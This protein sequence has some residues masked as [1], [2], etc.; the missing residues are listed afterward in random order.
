MT[1]AE[2]IADHLSSQGIRFIFG[3]PGSGFSLDLI[4]AASHRG[5]DFVATAHEGSAAMMAAVHGELT[6]IPGVCLSIRG[7]GAANLNSGI[8]YAWL[9]HSP[10]LAITETFSHKLSRP[11]ALQNLDHESVFS[12]TT[13]RREL[14]TPD[15]CLSTLWRTAVH[16]RPGPVHLDVPDGPADLEFRP[17]EVSLQE[18][19][20][21]DTP[22]ADV[23]VKRLRA[24]E[25]PVALVGAACARAGAGDALI[26][27]AEAWSIPVMTGVKARGLFPEDHP[28]FGGLFLAHGR[29]EEHITDQADLFL[30]IGWDRHEL[31]KE[32]AYEQRVLLLD[33]IDQGSDIPHAPEARVI[34]HLPDILDSLAV[35]GSEKWATEDVAAALQKLKERAEPKGP[36]FWPQ[37]VVEITRNL[38]PRDT[39]LVVETGIYQAVVEHVWISYAYGT[40]LGTLC[41]R[42]MGLALP[43]ALAAGLLRNDRRIVCMV[44]DGGLL[45][46]AGELELAGRMKVP[47]TLIVFNDRGLGTIRSRQATRGLERRGLDLGPVNFAKMAE[48]CGC[49]GIQV[50]SESE[51]ERAFSE[52]L[53]TDGPAVIDVQMDPDLYDQVLVQLRGGAPLKR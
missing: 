2:L 12:P 40:Y 28:L 30:T 24:A 5:I 18:S 45:M 11:P 7:P 33:C 10:L 52:A 38:S 50:A 21:P 34:G 20:K 3:I 31:M 49:R 1:G 39:I 4:D 22:D 43:A 14:L 36:G 25:K 19:S 47:L 37:Q 17:S 15:T 8:A 16:E 32:W 46:R 48:S 42:T 29:A 44:G 35:S 6:G 41:A 23:I 9:E 27:F 26:R 53:K 13:K 51:F